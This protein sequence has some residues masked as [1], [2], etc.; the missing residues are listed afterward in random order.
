[1]F[2]GPS[3]RNTG[4]GLCPAWRNDVIE[5]SSRRAERYRKIYTHIY[6]HTSTYAY[7]CINIC[8][9]THMYIYTY[10]QKYQ[11][12]PFYIYIYLHNTHIHTHRRWVL[13]FTRMCIL[14]GHLC[15]G[16]AEII[17]VPQWGYLYLPELGNAATPFLPPP[18]HIWAS[19]PYFSS[20]TS[21]L[22][23]SGIG[24]ARRFWEWITEGKTSST[25]AL[26]A[27]KLN[28]EDCGHW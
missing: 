21:S 13:A 3:R 10:I 7:I 18:L 17:P 24:S 25:R 28:L 16:V 5:T 4:D 26:H 20:C 12:A 6:L 9:Y 14:G 11:Q 23:A 19:Q 2:R 8:I 27:Y 15:P 22:F 1:M